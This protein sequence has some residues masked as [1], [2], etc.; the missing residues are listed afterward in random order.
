MQL[1]KAVRLD[2]L[3]NGLRRKKFDKIQPLIEREYVIQNCPNLNP[4]ILSFMNCN[5]P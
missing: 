4:N 3:S 5:N 2:N 1:K